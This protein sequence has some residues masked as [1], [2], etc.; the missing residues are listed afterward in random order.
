MS[1]CHEDPRLEANLGNYISIEF[2]DGTIE[3]GILSKGAPGEHYANYYILRANDR[4]I[5][6]RKGHMKKDNGHKLQSAY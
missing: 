5:A 6:F 2:L 4:D 1:K 3:Q